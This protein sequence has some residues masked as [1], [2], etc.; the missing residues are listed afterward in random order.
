[1]ND[2]TDRSEDG[3]VETGAMLQPRRQPLNVILHVFQQNQRVRRLRWR[4]D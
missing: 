2:E 1:M 3:I 4:I